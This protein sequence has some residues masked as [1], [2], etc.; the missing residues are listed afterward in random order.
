[1]IGEGSAA[2]S[3]VLHAGVRAAMVAA[4]RAKAEED[5]IVLRGHAMQIMARGCGA[6]EEVHKARGAVPAAE[7]PA[8]IGADGIP[9]IPRMSMRVQMMLLQAVE[10]VQ[11]Q[12]A[13][14][15]QMPSPLQHLQCWSRLSPEGR[16]QSAVHDQLL[17]QPSRQL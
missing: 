1:M 9:R 4:A 6:G 12:P 5:I 3:L 15:L 8:K 16:V 14:R 11:M 13:P 7:L 10:A 17:L 2:K